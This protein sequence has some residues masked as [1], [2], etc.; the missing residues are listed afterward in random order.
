[1]LYLFQ[2][3]QH[4]YVQQFAGEYIIFTFELPGNSIQLWMQIHAFLL[5]GTDSPKGRDLNII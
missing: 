5:K 4:I 1:M 2:T 3:I